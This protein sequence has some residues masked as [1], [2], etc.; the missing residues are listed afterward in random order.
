MPASERIID[1]E[2]LARELGSIR[3][4]AHPGGTRAEIGS[5][6][7]AR[8]ALEQLLGPDVFYAAVDHYVSGAP[9][10]ELAK[11]IL[12]HVR[13]W[14]GMVRCHETFARSPDLEVRRSAIELLRVVADRR[15]LDWVPQYLADPDEGI[16]MWGAGIVRQLLL[17]DLVE[18]DE[19]AATVELM[20]N[21]PNPVVQETLRDLE[22]LWNGGPA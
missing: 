13:P 2:R 11:S 22:A 6:S 15:A 20:A 14:S 4:A 19:C 8:A 21:H 1:W 5:T 12:R 18:R 17:S 3:P 10:S 7:L 16:Q 9:G